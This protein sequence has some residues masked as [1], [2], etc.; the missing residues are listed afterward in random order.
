MIRRI[1][2]AL[3]TA[4]FAAMLWSADAP[5][6]S[7]SDKE[8]AEGWSLLFDGTSFEGWRGYRQSAVPTDSWEIKDGLLKTLPRTRGISLIT[9]RKFNDFELSWEWR[10][11]R[12]GNNGLKYFVTEDRPDAPGHEYQMIDEGPES[13]IKVP[14]K[15]ETASYY[16]VLPPDRAKPLKP[17]G[18]WNVSRILVRGNYVEHWLNGAR[19]LTFELDSPQVKAGLAGSKFSKYPEFGD[20][21]P[22]YIMLTHHNDECWFRNIKIREIPG[23]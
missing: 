10:I 8:K 13:K 1:V 14:P 18:E 7:L 4:A 2:L 21:I 6:N 20:K 9:T 15:G 19:V 11:S 3:M 17:A 23:K 16:G 12:S 22:G 5:I